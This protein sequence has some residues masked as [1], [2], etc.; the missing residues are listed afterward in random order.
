MAAV[1]G[2]GASGS[3]SPTE[4]ATM[5]RKS[6]EIVAKGDFHPILYQTMKAL[7][8]YAGDYAQGNTAKSASSSG[9]SSQRQRGDAQGSAKS[10]FH[11]VPESLLDSSGTQQ[12]QSQKASVRSNR[13]SGVFTDMLAE[14][15]D[16][17]TDSAFQSEVSVH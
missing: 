1:N 17:E 4:L 15:A 8:V 13:S 6:A 14:M 16:S 3:I 5:L 9:S 11:D 2:G 12:Q 7:T 10:A